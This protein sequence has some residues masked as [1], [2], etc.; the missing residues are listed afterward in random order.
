MLH[1]GH[2]RA[3]YGKLTTRPLCQDL[4]RRG[5]AAWNVE[6]RRL[7]RGQGGGWPATFDDVAA[8]ID[9]L[10]AFAD[11]RHDRNDPRSNLAHPSRAGDALPLDLARVIAVGHSAGGQLALWAAGRPALPPGAPGAAPRVHLGGVVGLAAVSDLEK[12]GAPARALLGGDRDEVPDRFAQADPK[13]TLP[14]DAPVLLVHPRDDQTVPVRRS[15]A[16]ATAAQAAGAAVELVEPP[17]GHRDVIDP[18]HEAWHAAAERL[19][20]LA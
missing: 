19:S 1:G 9:H 4:A 3:R 15:R 11:P 18:G 20:H 6:Y 2:W 5:W 17:G 12:A 8:A 7:G 16:Y 10:A 13:L 14:L